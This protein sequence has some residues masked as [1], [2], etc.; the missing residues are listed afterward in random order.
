VELAVV[1]EAT[2]LA[3]DEESKNNPDISQLKR[4]QGL[5]C[6]R[7]DIFGFRYAVK[8]KR[9]I[10]VLEPQSILSSGG[11]LSGSWPHC[12]L[13]FNFCSVVNPPAMSSLIRT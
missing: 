5:K 3:D 11:H 1:D 6:I 8:V 2:R 9:G 4:S 7:P 10:A 13:W 12:E